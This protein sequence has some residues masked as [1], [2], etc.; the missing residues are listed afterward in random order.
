MRGIQ[1]NMA[2]VWNDLQALI[3]GVVEQMNQVGELKQR[4]GGLHFQGGQLID[5]LSGSFFG[6]QKG[7]SRG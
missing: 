7:G 2:S 1:I 5:F 4:T 3:S 6:F